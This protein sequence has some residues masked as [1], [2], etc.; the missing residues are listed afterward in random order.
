MMQAKSLARK[1][2][3]GLKPKD[4]VGIPW[5]VAFALQ[6]D[7][8]TLR[9]DIIWQKPNVMPESVSDR[10][11]KSHEY[12]FL[13]TKSRKYFFDAAAIEEDAK[14]D[15]WGDSTDRK[16]QQGMAS[17]L[18][19]LKSDLPIRDKRNKR[20][21][22]SI[23]TRPYKGDHFAAFPPALVEP[24]ILAGCPRDGMVLDPFLGSG[25]TALV[26]LKHGR[27]YVGIELNPEYVNLAKK[28]IEMRDMSRIGTDRALV[29]AALKMNPLFAR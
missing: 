26:A 1:A 12:I 18:K 3:A 25:T 13:M 21:V 24:C 2:P 5:R 8:W 15:K 20:S 7:G 17:H 14:W 27:R 23:N 22:W 16:H 6:A 4:L 9:Q 19:K 28:R 11:T 29:A 10:C